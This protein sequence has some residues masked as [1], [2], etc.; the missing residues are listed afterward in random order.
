MKLLADRAE[1][2]NLIQSVDASGLTIAGRRHVRSLLVPATGPIEPWA[3][4]DVQAL[5]SHDW[6][7]VLQWRPELVVL[8]S[9]V[10]LRFAHPSRLAALINAGI[11]V[12]TM[13]TAA[14]CRTYNILALEGRRVLAAL[15]MGGSGPL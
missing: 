13:D 5:E 7:A 12:E 2:V 3:P 1:G 4:V 8:G 11:G 14:A 15:L 9:G 6:D 10:S